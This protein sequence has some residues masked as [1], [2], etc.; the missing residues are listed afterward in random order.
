MNIPPQDVLIDFH[1]IKFLYDNF[2]FAD[3]DNHFWEM[4]EQLMGEEDE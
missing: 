4:L 1:H 3:I 2:S